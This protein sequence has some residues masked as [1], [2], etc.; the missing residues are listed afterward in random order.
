MCWLLI[1]EPLEP[2]STSRTIIG[3]PRYFSPA[4]ATFSLPQSTTILGML[5]ALL[6]ITVSNGNVNSLD[7]I[8]Y[9]AS[10]LKQ[11]MS[12]KT[13]QLLGPFP[14][15]GKNLERLY[16]PVS[17]SIYVPVD[18]INEVIKYVEGTNPYK[19]FYL[20]TDICRESDK[21]PVCIKT[22]NMVLTGVSLERSHDRGEK[23]IKL[24]YMYKY[25]L[26]IYIDIATG[27]PIDVKMVYV[28]NCELHLKETI[29]RIGGESR[30]AKIRT[31][32][33]E[34]P[35]I[36]DV[37]KKTINPLMDIKP[38]IYLATNFVPFVTIKP[39]TI[40]LNDINAVKGLEFLDEVNDI[41]GLPQLVSKR[42]GIIE[43][44]PPK[45]VIE[46]LGLGYSESYGRRRPQVLA[47]PPGTLLL[48]RKK[49]VLATT[50]IIQTLW[51]IGYATLF[52]LSQRI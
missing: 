31:I 12:C 51:D 48:I 52:E 10:V 15:T 30:I 7:D 41:I 6:G 1:I 18:R 2:L 13:P 16:V 5:G 17:P 49:E 44:R 42:H 9:V 8:K 21:I 32:K 37:I 19:S 35:K 26:V 34:E 36:L 40:G 45:V 11:K 23:I 46:R 25:P 50:G 47:L 24:G 14:A 28:L 39:G 43:I 22:R 4:V 33:A 3:G 29:V 20:D 38:G 27:R